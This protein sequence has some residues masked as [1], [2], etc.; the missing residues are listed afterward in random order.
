MIWRKRAK[1][2]F[3]SFSK[4]ELHILKYSYSVF[5]TTRFF[6]NSGNTQLSLIVRGEN[7]S[8]IMNLAV[9]CKFLAAYGVMCHMGARAS[10][11]RGSCDIH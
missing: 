10:F 7:G 8:Q 11:F 4:F 3:G 5:K 2:I 9:E 6:S 1:K